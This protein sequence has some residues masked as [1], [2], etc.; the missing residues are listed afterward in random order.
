MGELIDLLR[1]FGYNIKADPGKIKPKEV[2]RMI[3]DCAGTPQEDL[4]RSLT[5]RSMKQARYSTECVGHYGLAAKEYT[6]FTSPIRRYPD[7]QIHR[8]LKEQL[9]DKLKKKPID[10][11][12][13]F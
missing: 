7:L 2:Q 11:E 13:W 3:A 6:H 4:I 12:A 9:H 8:I 1:G 5:L 10:Y